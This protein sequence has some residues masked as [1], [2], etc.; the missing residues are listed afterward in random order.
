MMY[1]KA[2][3]ILLI[4]KKDFSLQKAPPA[5]SFFNAYRICIK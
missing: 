3:R 1:A 5:T 4:Q 2:D